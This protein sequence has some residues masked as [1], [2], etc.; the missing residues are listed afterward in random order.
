MQT[1]PIR[2]SR[3]SVSLDGAWRFAFVQDSVTPL[4]QMTP[5]TTTQSSSPSQASSTPEPRPTT[6][7]AASASTAATSSST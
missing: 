4:D 2:N 1:Y 6:D 3:R 7:A 5:P